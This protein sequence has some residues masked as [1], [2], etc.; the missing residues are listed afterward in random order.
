M[1]IN[2]FRSCYSGQPCLPSSRAAS[3]FS[4]GKSVGYCALQPGG[5]EPVSTNTF[6]PSS[7]TRIN[8]HDVCIPVFN[9]WTTPESIFAIIVALSLVITFL[10]FVVLKCWLALEYGIMCKKREIH[11]HYRAMVARPET[12]VLHGSYE[13]GWLM[14]NGYFIH[15][16]RRKLSKKIE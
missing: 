1:G 4:R 11:I 10:V 6:L 3:T 14:K 9:S 5:G 13:S 2:P 12:P 16:N 15:S 8:V 7:S